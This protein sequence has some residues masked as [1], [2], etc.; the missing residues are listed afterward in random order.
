MRRLSLHIRTSFWRMVYRVYDTF[1]K[2]VSR[3]SKEQAI[4]IA[5]HYHLENEVMTA[6]QHGCTPDEALQEWDIY[7]YKG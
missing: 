6:M 2:P 4:S 7:P 3:H 1:H 5:K